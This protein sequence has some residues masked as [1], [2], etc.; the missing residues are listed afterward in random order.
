MPAMEYVLAKIENQ[1]VGV[2]GTPQAWCYM[3]L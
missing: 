1:R 3:Q 2:V